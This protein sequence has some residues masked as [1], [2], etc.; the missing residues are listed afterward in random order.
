MLNKIEFSKFPRKFPP[1]IKKFPWIPEREFQV[2]LV[3]AL[4][5]STHAISY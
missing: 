1:R 5:D 2:A 3:V 4:F